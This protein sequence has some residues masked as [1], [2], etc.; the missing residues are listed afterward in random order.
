MREIRTGCGC[1]GWLW[2]IVAGCGR[3][4]VVGCG[5]LQLAV[6]GCGWLRAAGNSWLSVAIVG[7]AWLRQPSGECCWLWVTVVGCD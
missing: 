3:L 6:A 5:W 2:L 1:G 4:A 7:S